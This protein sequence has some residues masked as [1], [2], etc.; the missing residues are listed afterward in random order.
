M[1]KGGAK[2]AHNTKGRSKMEKYIVIAKVNGTDYLTR[3]NAESEINAEHS[4]LNW[5]RCSK[6]GY[7]VEACMAYNFDAMK[8]ETFRGHA[9]NAEPVSLS[10]LK[11]IIAER[12]AEL[13]MKEQAESEIEKIEKEIK[14]LTEKLAEDKKILEQ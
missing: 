3:T 10:E 14:R 9:L 12:N 8:T 7:G 5:G 11:S 1:N 2:A 13:I 4:I 6:F